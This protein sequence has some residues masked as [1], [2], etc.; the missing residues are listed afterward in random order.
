MEEHATTGYSP[1]QS[2]FLIDLPQKETA[3]SI[4][5]LNVLTGQ[6]VVAPPDGVI[7]GTT[8]IEDELRRIEP[9][10]D[11][12]WRGAIYSLNPNNPDASRH[13]CTSSREILDQI[14]VLAAPNADVIASNPRCQVTDK[15]DPTRREKIHYLL[16]RRGFDLDLLDDFVENDIQN[17]IELFN[18]FN[19]ATH[20][21]A[22]KFSLPELL[23][24]KKRVEDGI[25]F[26]AG[27]AAEPS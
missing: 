9:D 21:P 25:I 3:N 24:I 22:G 8:E 10:L 15:G 18:V 27:I 16:K 2:R 12:R 1:E 26:V 17:I 11:N 14:L 20:G 23:T 19:S 5:V 7:L 6:G 4:N 13:F